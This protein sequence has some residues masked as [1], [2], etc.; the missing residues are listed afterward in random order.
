MPKA[1]TPQEGL[2]RAIR[3][4]RAARGMSQEDLSAAAEIDVRMLRRIEAG[5]NPT[6]ATLRSLASALDVTLVELV[7]MIE[8]R[9]PAAGT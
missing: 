6:L 4:L 5:A 1:A 3:E 8:E 2:A 7:E 9:E